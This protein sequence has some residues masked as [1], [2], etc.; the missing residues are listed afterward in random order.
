MTD[1]HFVVV[2]VV[3]QEPTKMGTIIMLVNGFSYKGKETRT[4]NQCSLSIETV[5]VSSTGGSKSPDEQSH[6]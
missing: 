2:V 1:A 3:L 5:A 6:R 4:V